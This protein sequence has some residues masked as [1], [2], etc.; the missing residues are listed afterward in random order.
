MT[1]VQPVVIPVDKIPERAALLILDDD[2]IPSRCRIIS[3]GDP[4][5][6]EREPF[7]KLE[8][9]ILALQGLALTKTVPL[10]RIIGD[11]PLERLHELEH[12]LRTFPDS[13]HIHP[14]LAIELQKYS[15][16]QI[17]KTVP[18]LGRPIHRR[19]P[20]RRLGDEKIPWHRV[21]FPAPILEARHKGSLDR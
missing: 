14:R 7:Q 20:D 6:N 19:P 2:G 12:D 17:P 9:L 8:G 11:I 16:H 5:W 1:S 18:F 4:L 13:E 3:V 21:G 10:Q 15:Q